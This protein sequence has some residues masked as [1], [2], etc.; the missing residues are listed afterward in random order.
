MTTEQKIKQFA[1]YRGQL[2]LTNG[3]ERNFK[4]AFHGHDEAMGKARELA[5]QQR[6]GWVQIEDRLTNTYTEYGVTFSGE[7]E[8]RKRDC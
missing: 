1:V 5:E 2:G 4:G 6:G 7:L 8:K 3:G